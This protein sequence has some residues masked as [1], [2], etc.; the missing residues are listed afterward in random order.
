M[1]RYSV[2]LFYVVAFIVSI[3]A[4]LPHKKLQLSINMIQCYLFVNIGVNLSEL[5][6]ELAFN[7]YE[8]CGYSRPPFLRNKKATYNVDGDDKTF[9]SDLCILMLKKSPY[10][11]FL[12]ESSP[13]KS[14]LNKNPFNTSGELALDDFLIDIYYI[15]GSLDLEDRN[16]ATNLQNGYVLACELNPKKDELFHSLLDKRLNYEDRP[17]SQEEWPCYE[18]INNVNLLRAYLEKAKRS[19]DDYG[20]KLLFDKLLKIFS[21]H[22]ASAIIKLQV[23]YWQNIHNQQFFQEDINW[24][25]YL[26][27]L[28]EEQKINPA[29]IAGFIFLLLERNL[30]D[31]A[32]FCLVQYLQKFP[33]DETNSC[34]FYDLQENQDLKDILNSYNNIFSVSP[35]LWFQDQKIRPILDLEQVIKTPLRR[36][37]R[38][39]AH[40]YITSCADGEHK[41]DFAHMMLDELLGAQEQNLYLPDML[42]NAE[43]KIGFNHDY[44]KSF[45]IDFCKQDQ[46]ISYIKWVGKRYN[47]DYVAMDKLRVRLTRLFNAVLNESQRRELGDFKD[48]RSFHVQV[49]SL[50]SKQTGEREVYLDSLAVNMDNGHS[51]REMITN[52]VKKNELI[53]NI[54]N[55]IHDA[56]QQYKSWLS[57]KFPEGFQRSERSVAK[58]GF[59]T[60]LRHTYR[61]KY[62]ADAF[63]AEVNSIKDLDRLKDRIN[64]EIVKGPLHRHSFIAFLLDELR[65]VEDMPWTAVQRHDKYDMDEVCQELEIQAPSKGYFF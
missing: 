43:D 33:V 22:A 62:R 50:I 11:R 5:L 7:N 1:A 21:H 9:Q 10:V 65:Q 27:N 29:C 34:F 63:C 3:C 2:V 49:V 41:L 15:L 48:Y 56:A 64:K 26:Y 52:I 30:N 38:D 37:D 40:L 42:A 14:F 25:D 46:L 16:L 18:F 32:Q 45:Y 61:G 53:Q 58:N 31:A 24:F 36:T 60:W 19:S 8:R 59:F 13:H 54:K 17:C 23:E 47:F 6:I 28:P 35:W 4:M 55:R 20:V 12:T 44:E 39:Y 51:E 57:Q